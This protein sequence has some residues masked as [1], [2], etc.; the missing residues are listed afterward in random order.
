MAAP[1]FDAIAG[2]LN[3]ID[4]V[5]GW[6]RGALAGDIVGHRIALP[7]PQSDWWD[8]NPGVQFWNAGD[9]KRLLESYHIYTYAHGFDDTEIWF[10]VLQRQARWAEY[11]LQRAGAPVIMDTVDGRNVAWAA[12]PVHGGKMP[13]RWDDRETHTAPEWAERE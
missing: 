13:G 4:L 8:E 1:W 12:N 9:T 3:L 6:I 2:P 11:L 7:H 10:H 5:E